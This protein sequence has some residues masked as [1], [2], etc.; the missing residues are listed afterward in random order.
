MSDGND[1]LRRPL[2]PR[3]VGTSIAIFSM[4]SGVLATYLF[5]SKLNGVSNAVQIVWATGSAAY[6]VTAFFFLVGILKRI[7]WLMMPFMCMLLMAIAVY[8]MVFDFI[9]HNL[10]IA[11][12]AAVTVS[13]IFLGLALH[14]AR[15]ETR[16]RPDRSTM[17][18][19]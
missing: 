7:R 1:T 13:F 5:L 16:S 9:I 10:A 4:G 17:A 11:V 15:T 3:P 19:S 18:L 12:F 14:I 6:A 2:W 8:T